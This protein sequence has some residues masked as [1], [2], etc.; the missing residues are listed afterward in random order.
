[1][2]LEWF[3]FLGVFL[4]L[5]ELLELCEILGFGNWKVERLRGFFFSV[6]AGKSR[7]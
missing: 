5:L 6:S 1:M 2:L 3:G 4:E 7:C